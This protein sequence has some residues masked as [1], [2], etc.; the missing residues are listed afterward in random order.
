MESRMK[1]N[2]SGKH[3]QKERGAA[4]LTVLLVSVLL[5]S[6]GLA[7]VTSTALSTTTTIDAAAELQAYAAAEAGLEAALNVMRGNIAPDS[8]LAGTKMNFRNAADPAKSNK[9][10]DPKSTGSNASSRMSG[11]LK[12]SYQ[13]ASDSSDWRVPVT[14]SYAPL[15][16]IAY[17]ISIT[18]PDDPGALASR[19]ITTDSSYSPSR[20]IIQSTGYGPKGS[21]K[22][23]EMIVKK[24]SFEFSAPGAITLAG[25]DDI[26]LDLGNSDKVSYSGI[27]H[28]T[29]PHS[30]IAAIAVSAGNVS[31]AQKVIDDMKEDVQVQPGNATALTDSN[32][33]SFAKSADAAR[34]FLNEMR[35]TASSQGRLFADKDAAV[36]AG[37][38]GTTTDPKFTFIDNYG[39]E[40]VDLGSN[41]Q[42]SG[43]LIVTGDLDTN[44][45]TEFEGIILVLGKG[46]MTRKGGGGG[47]M[48]GA[49][50]IANFDPNGDPGDEFG[51][52]SF[53]INGGGNSSVVYD[54]VWQEHA[55]EISGLT[56]QGVREFH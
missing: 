14:D 38:L 18:D 2:A 50:F 12:Y 5:L 20:L 48:R 37:G 7:L 46:T 36:A 4:L 39:G 32:T 26:T 54:S 19:K 52:P 13:N 56:V 55:L 53:S 24:G 31:D 43:L 28:G 23:L 21:V 29:P 33:P 25:G 47:V 22:R 34:A 41:H 9:V 42:G 40:A 49:I 17:K 15:T 51:D 1:I 3:R 30:A 45:N 35:A 27:D 8:T 6:A 44:G 10:G 16:G 11:W